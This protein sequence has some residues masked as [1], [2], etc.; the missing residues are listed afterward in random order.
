MDYRVTSLIFKSKNFEPP[1]WLF[2]I[3]LFVAD[4]TW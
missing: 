3:K 1:E 2:Q 4:S